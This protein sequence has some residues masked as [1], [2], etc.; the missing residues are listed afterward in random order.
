MAKSD[1]AEEV[2]KDEQKDDP[3]DEPDHEARDRMRTCT[4]EKQQ[5]AWE[6]DSRVIRF[7]GRDLEGA[8][9]AAGRS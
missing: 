9:T 7:G 4:D 1:D 2:D 8:S 5:E 6:S 3:Q